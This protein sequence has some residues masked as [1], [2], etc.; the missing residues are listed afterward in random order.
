MGA[1]DRPLPDGEALVAEIN[2]RWIDN[3]G[4]GRRDAPLFPRRG[5]RRLLDSG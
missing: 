2:G 4:T 5:S 3:I 1:L